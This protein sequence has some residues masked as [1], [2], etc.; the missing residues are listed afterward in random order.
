MPAPV[1][2]F[3]APWQALIIP[4]WLALMRTSLLDELWLI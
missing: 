3:S 4:A 2:L 1:P